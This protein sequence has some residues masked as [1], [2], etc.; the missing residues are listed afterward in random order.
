MTDTE[1]TT[2]LR[3]KDVMTKSLLTVSATATIREAID[4]FE[5]HR[6]SS[7]V[8]DRRDDADEFG[9]LTVRDIATKVIAEGGSVDRA[10][11]Y[12]VMR[13][14]VLVLQADMNI[15]YA[16]RLLTRFGVSRAVVTDANR[17]PIG[18]VTLRDMVLGH[19]S[20]WV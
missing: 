5:G 18:M 3:V 2:V 13:K 14:P 12:E 1:A 10:Y 4:L 17:D 15:K 20:A 11:V 19:G 6:V 7:L 8:I 9:L 16:V